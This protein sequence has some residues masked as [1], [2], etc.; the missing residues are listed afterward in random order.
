MSASVVARGTLIVSICLTTPRTTCRLH[1]KFTIK[2]YCS[3]LSGL[4]IRR[5]PRIRTRLVLRD[6]KKMTVFI[7]LEAYKHYDAHRDHFWRSGKLVAR[8]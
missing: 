4:D 2:D 1:Q 7:E 3:L 8:N 6:N 5:T